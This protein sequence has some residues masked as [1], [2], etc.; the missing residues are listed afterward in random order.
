MDRLTKVC[1]EC[2]EWDVHPCG[3]AYI[4]T[5]GCQMNVSDSEIVASVLQSANYAVTDDLNDADAILVNTCAIRDGAEAKI[6]HRLRQLKAVK[7][8]REKESRRA[9]KKLAGL[10]KAGK[11]GKKN[12]GAGA[13]GGSG[14]GV[15]RGIESAAAPGG[16]ARVPRGARGARPRDRRDSR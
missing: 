5:Y 10:G 6:W 8:T 14:G 7:T 16:G 2:G 11:G 15:E 9:A 3:K 4:E 12:P 13:G 1:G